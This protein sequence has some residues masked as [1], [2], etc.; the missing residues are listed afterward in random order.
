[1]KVG[2]QLV[3]SHHA[4]MTDADMFRNEVKMGVEAEAMGFDYVACVEHHFTDYA[5]CPDNAQLLSYIAAKT[6]RI[7]LMPAAFILP[8]NNPLRI[9]EKITMLDIQ[10]EGRA[11]VPTRPSGVPSMPALWRA[12]P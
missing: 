5:M 8:W 9:V 3:V 12:T 10:S 7:Q 1:M 4:D 2:I 11:R 6:K